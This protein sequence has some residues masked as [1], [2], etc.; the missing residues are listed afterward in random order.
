M[1]LELANEHAAVTRMAPLSWLVKETHDQECEWRR[2]KL[3]HEHRSG[4]EVE[5]QFEKTALALTHPQTIAPE[6]RRVALPRERQKLKSGPGRLHGMCPCVQIGMWSNRTP[7]AY[8]S[9]SMDGSVGIEA[10]P[11]VSR[12][13]DERPLHKHSPS[14]HPLMT[15]EI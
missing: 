1:C 9:S 4:T 11:R 10:T 3:H 5:T 7:S 2:E 13:R 15:S 12:D 8:G 14:P 6:G